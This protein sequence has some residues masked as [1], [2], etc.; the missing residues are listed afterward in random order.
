MPG[1]P[2]TDK[3][4][5]VGAEQLLADVQSI[6]ENCGMSADDA[7]LLADSL[8]VADVRG[9]HSH[10]VLRVPDYVRRLTRDGVNPKG[11][12]RV[13]RDAGAALVVD[14]DNAMGQIACHFAMERAL[15]RAAG[16]GVAA[17][18]VRGSNHCGALFY[19]A[20]MA[21][22]R[23]MIG[24]VTT[25]ALPTMAPWGGR[26]KILGINP[27][28]VAIPS[29]DEPPIVLDV[30][31]SGSSHGKIRVFH[32]KGL[33]I[34]DGW[35]FDKDGNPTND[36]AAAIEGLLQPIGGFKGAGLAVVMGVLSSLLSGAAF[37]TELGNMIDGPRAGADGQFVMALN[38]SAFED[39]ARFR[40]RVDGVVRQIRASKPAPGFER[41][42][43]PGELEHLIEQG[44]RRGG[45]PLNPETLAGLQQFLGGS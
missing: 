29:G 10:G 20:M 43:S 40:A 3:E 33:P 15:D 45:I 44:Y 31:F 24:L 18:A 36:D 6:F 23:G 37:G 28:A 2:V 9:V 13:V 16:T 32:Q 8:V 35:A 17:A 1:Y 5:R 38:V 7:R 34:P 14:G 30:A 41:C 25:N 21:L 27:L 11:R 4:T 12:P 26:D 19:F 39:L 42:Y 22:E